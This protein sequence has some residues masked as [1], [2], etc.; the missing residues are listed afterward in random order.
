M[1][2]TILS[3]KAAIYTTRRLAQSARLRGARVRILDPVQVEMHL[4]E[5]P[6]LYYQRRKLLRTDVVIPRIAPS[7][8]AYG[9]AVVNHFTMMGV[10]TLNDAAGI[11]ASRNKMRAL[12]LLAAHGV[13]VPPTVMAASARDLR[14]LVDLVGGVPVLINVLTEKRGVMVCE[15]LQSMEAALE[16]VLA[17][18][19]NLLV[20][21]YVRRKRER[22]LRARVV[23][24]QVIAWVERRPRPGRLL[25][26]LAK[27]AKLKAVGVPAAMDAL[28]VKAARVIGLDV[29]AV[30]LLEAGSGPMVFD[31]NSSPGLK[32][33]EA[34]TGKD[35]A[36]PIVGRA[37][38][39][40]KRYT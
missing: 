1:H 16:A 34:A 39:L 26:T 23:G 10:P 4:D 22:D 35:L 24:E 18:G 32:G 14:E 19:H 11:A 13:P 38:E 36:L 40:V 29:A 37:E 20:Q 5:A 25:H 8:Q 6:G 21:R 3:R 7:V 2:L 31:V 9:L 30:D 12:Q 27:G 17:M 28:A 33:L 15:T